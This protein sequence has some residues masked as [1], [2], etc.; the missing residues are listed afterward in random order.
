MA[1]PLCNATRAVDQHELEKARKRPMKLLGVCL[2]CGNS[3]AELAWPVTS[4]ETCSPGHPATS[5]MYSTIANGKCDKK[6]DP[7]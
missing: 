4:V 2:P 7:S 5:D 6:H 3:A 1:R